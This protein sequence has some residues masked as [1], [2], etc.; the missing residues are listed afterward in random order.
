MTYRVEPV[1]VYR[2][3]RDDN[4]RMPSEYDNP[5]AARDY[6]QE[7]ERYAQDLNGYAQECEGLRD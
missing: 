5:K 7:L 1:T 4:V 2:V 3:I 6:A